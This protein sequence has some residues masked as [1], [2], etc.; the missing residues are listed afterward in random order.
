ME[1]FIAAYE[2]L[3]KHENCNGKI[4]VVGFC[5]EVDCQYDGS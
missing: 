3:S 1:D 2:Y 4:G 5:F